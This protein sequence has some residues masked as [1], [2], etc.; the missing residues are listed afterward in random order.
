METLEY[1]KY[2]ENLLKKLLN[3]TDINI[4]KKIEKVFNNNEED[5]YYSLS[6]EEKEGIELGLQQIKEGKTIP[7]ETFIAKHRK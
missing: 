6:E 1:L 2:R 7:Y 4:L 5:F 3:T